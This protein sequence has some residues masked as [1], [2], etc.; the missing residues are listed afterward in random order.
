[1]S[2]RKFVAKSNTIAALAVGCLAW[3]FTAN[4]EDLAGTPKS[5]STVGFPDHF[6]LVVGSDHKSYECNAITRGPVI[7]LAPSCMTLPSLEDVPPQSLIAP[8]LCPSR[9]RL[10]R[11]G[12]QCL[13]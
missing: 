8:S 1:M 10:L 9:I 2:G 13:R 5:S 4:A 11:D 12:R 6:D 3:A 7:L